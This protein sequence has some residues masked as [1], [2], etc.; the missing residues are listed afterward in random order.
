M[1]RGLE[2]L[3]GA[4][5]RA[6]DQTYAQVVREHQE[7]ILMSRMLMQENAE[8]EMAQRNRM[9]QARQN[10]IKSDN[11][12]ARD[13]VKE[14]GMDRRL[15]KQIEAG[16][17]EKNP[18]ASFKWYSK[19]P[20]EEQML[21]DQ[22]GTMGTMAQKAL[23]GPNAL[24]MEEPERRGY[25]E[26]LNRARITYRILAEKHNPTAYKKINDRYNAIYGRSKLDPPE[27]KGKDKPK[28]YDEFDEYLR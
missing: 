23:S 19:L 22:A 12:I 2:N 6:L 15:D 25:L 7:K 16:R 4:A 9:F 28:G 10:Q 3:A 27:V 21:M 20:K 17:F 13:D 11:Q 24:I 5:S 8:Q 18:W 26:M 1:N 14:A